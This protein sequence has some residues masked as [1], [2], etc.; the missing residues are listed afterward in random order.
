[1]ACNHER[2][3]CVL[4]TEPLGKAKVFHLYEQPA[5]TGYTGISAHVRCLDKEPGLQF[6]PS[7]SEQMIR[8]MWVM[9]KLLAMAEGE[10]DGN[11]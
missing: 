6:G 8:A 9:N 3:C 5:D 4:C 11:S 7:R 2:F 10:P 1:M